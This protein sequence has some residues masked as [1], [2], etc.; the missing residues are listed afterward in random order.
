LSDIFIDEFLLVTG[1]STGDGIRFL[2]VLVS[3]TLCVVNLMAVPIS[4][5]CIKVPI[6]FGIF[7]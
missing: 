7:W 1:F 4:D 6:A 5:A 2:T 3:S